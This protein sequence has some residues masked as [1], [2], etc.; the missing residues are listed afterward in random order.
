MWA[1][2]WTDPDMQKQP[3]ISIDEER[4]IVAEEKA[5]CLKGISP[6]H[7]KLLRSLYRRSKILPVTVIIKK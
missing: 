1:W 2:V 5:K 3:I 7:G 6:E 4:W